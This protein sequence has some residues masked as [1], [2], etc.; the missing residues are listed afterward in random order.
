ML[1]KIGN[2]SS[3]LII[4]LYEG[5]YLNNPRDT[6]ATQEK[7]SKKYNSNNLINIARKISQT[8]ETEILHES[9]HNFKPFGDSGSML[10]QADLSLYN[11][12]TLHLEESHITFHTYIEDI[13]KNYLIVR[14][15]FHISSCSE[16]NVFYSMHDIF[17][18][19]TYYNSLL[20]DLVTI[21]YL[22]RGA[23]FGNHSGDIIND[24]FDVSDIKF[25]NLYHILS[26]NKFMNSPNTKNYVLLLNMKDM[27]EKLQAENSFLSIRL[28]H[29]LRNFLLQSYANDYDKRDLPDLEYIQ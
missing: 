20:P 1:K 22:R 11:S 5:F 14:L 7:I 21:D 29:Q 25:K 26:N 6:L 17:H 28:I 18:N 19:S 24:D 13:L 23:K 3:T 15:E 16:A 10:I 27:V 12:A 8:I 9:S 4:N 2:T